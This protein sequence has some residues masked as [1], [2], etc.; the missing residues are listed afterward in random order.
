MSALAEQQTAAA[1]VKENERGRH[2][3]SKLFIHN[4]IAKIL[5]ESFFVRI[6][7]TVGAITSKFVL[8]IDACLYAAFHRIRA[9]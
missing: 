5:A 8:E 4:T 7:I 6:K 9:L 2:C 3:S 1:H